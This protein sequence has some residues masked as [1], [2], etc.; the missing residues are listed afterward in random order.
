[1]DIGV[2]EINV[3]NLLH[4]FI[5]PHLPLLVSD[6]MVW[7]PVWRLYLFSDVGRVPLAP[8]KGSASNSCSF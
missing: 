7:D 6:V 1:M 3:E 5:D 8:A 4:L 2:E